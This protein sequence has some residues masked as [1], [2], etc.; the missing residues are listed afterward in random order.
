MKHEGIPIE[1]GNVQPFMVNLPKQDAERLFDQERRLTCLSTGAYHGD[2]LEAYNNHILS[3]PWRTLPLFDS[4]PAKALCADLRKVEAD[5]SDARTWVEKKR[6]ECLEAFDKFHEY[7]QSCKNRY[8]FSEPESVYDNVRLGE[9]VF[10]VGGIYKFKFHYEALVFAERDAYVK[11]T[12]ATHNRAFITLTGDKRD[13]V[14]RNGYIKY[15]PGFG[16]LES[17]IGTNK[18]RLLDAS[19]KELPIG[20]FRDIETYRELERF[21]ET[22]SLEDGLN[23]IYRTTFS[24]GEGRPACLPNR[25]KL[26]QHPSL[27]RGNY[28]ESCA[29]MLNHTADMLIDIDRSITH[30]H[31]VRTRLEEFYGLDKQ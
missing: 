26:E 19:V 29:N 20:S 3:I 30:A 25:T 6:Y 8:I 27:W 1:D 5:L 7:Y 11:I 18:F 15:T 16:V 22:T 13:G 23:D 31:W 17:V 9:A 24:A 2:G 12:G 21:N 10:H 14:A 4:T 28:D